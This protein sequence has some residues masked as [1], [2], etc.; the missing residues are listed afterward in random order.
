MGKIIGLGGGRYDNGEI[1]NIAEYIRSLSSKDRP[2]LVFLP[3][4]SFDNCDENN[5]G[6]KAFVS[7]GC[8]CCVLRLTD[9]NLT[10]DEIEE[11]LLEAD[12]I[13]ADGGNLDFMMKTFRKSGAD[14]A[15][16]RAYERGAVLSGLS[17]GMMC[18]FAEGYD[19]CGEN[20][21]FMFVDCLGFLPYS[22]CPHFQ[23]GNWHTFEEA[24]K[25]RA[26]SGFAAD[27]GA[28]LVYSGGEFSV[29]YG[30]EGGRVYFFDKNNNHRKEI[31]GGIEP[32]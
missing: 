2:R 10:Y 11:T 8:E 21:A 30:N 27:N 22:A 5:D 1:M 19:D 6:L 3:T 7:L 20:G 29:I 9:E 12:I 16:R 4:A 26:F 15:L 14:K 25:G 24:L 23:G 28:A 17:S 31:F 18:W 13:Y 32:V